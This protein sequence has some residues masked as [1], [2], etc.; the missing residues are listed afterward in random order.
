M[1][2]AKRTTEHPQ[3]PVMLAVLAIAC[4]LLLIMSAPALASEVEEIPQE[5]AL[6]EVSEDADQ[7]EDALEA[8]AASVEPQEELLVQEVVEEQEP[9]QAVGG[10]FVIYNTTIGWAK[11]EGSSGYAL[12]MYPT[13]SKT[14]PAAV[15][16]YANGI[17]SSSAPTL[18]Y[19]FVAPEVTSFTGGFKF[20]YKAYGTSGATVTTCSNGSMTFASSKAMYYRFMGTDIT[21]LA[22]AGSPELRTVYNL[23]KQVNLKTLGTNA[24]GNSPKLYYV[25]LPPNLETIETHA[26]NKCK[27]LTK[28][29][30]PSSLT[31]IK[32]SVF[33]D[34]TTLKTL[35]NFE[36]T[37]VEEIRYWLFRNCD[38]LETITLPKTLKTIMGGETTTNAPFES[39]DSLKT[40]YIPLTLETIKQSLSTYSPVLENVYFVDYDTEKDIV[41]PKL[42]NPENLFKNTPFNTAGSDSWINVP[43]GSLYH[44]K[45]A[46]KQWADHIRGGELSKTSEIVVEGLK[47]TYN[48]NGAPIAPE[49]TFKWRGLELTP[50]EQIKVEFKNNVNAGTAK[51]VITGKDPYFTGTKTVEFEIADA[52]KRL[53]GNNSLGTMKAIVDEGFNA[54][55]TDVAILATNKSFKDALAASALAGKHNAPILLTA[56]NTLSTHTANELKRLKPSKVFIVGG[57]LA[58]SED[59]AN[60]VKQMG[61]TVSRISGKNAV[62]TSRAIFMEYLTPLDPTISIVPSA[63][64]IATQK[65]F[66]DA[67]SIAPWSYFHEAPILLTSAS[68]ELS[69]ESLD[70]MVLYM[71]PKYSDRK[72]IIVGGTSA[73]SA[74]TEQ[75]IKDAGYANVIRLAGSTAVKTSEAIARWAV[76]EGNLGRYENGARRY[77]SLAQVGV[78]TRGD[79]KDALCGAALM[80]RLGGPILLVNGN[81]YSAVNNVLKG[82][83]AEVEH[84]YI[85]GGPLAI[86]EDVE[87]KI[88]AIK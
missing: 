71:G 30:I 84:G 59:V 88:R 5:P 81:N 69:Q 2:A 53:A 10:D 8:A 24:F 14:E 11:P 72:V 21:T 76:S 6:A 28:L 85:F 29:T 87:A 73:V 42:T 43:A 64:V 36:N 41:I 37:Q 56:P 26:F 78:A 33:E 18:S 22:N 75:R 19:I 58:V 44:W 57:T 1:A 55:D 54:A 38:A 63:I 60:T 47:E 83:S 68:G 12:T 80:G 25:A 70:R 79:Y 66:A 62:E 82:K 23:E 32:H 20:K 27:A 65:D 49:L 17:F 48:Y 50:G 4:T 9:P 31:T 15:E 35:T 86:S 77:M 7:P 61:I 46:W 39:C 16:Y 13:N 74:K 45:Q 67:L 51:L 3:N 40:I 52:W 34:C